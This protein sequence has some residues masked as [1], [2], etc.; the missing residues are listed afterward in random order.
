MADCFA[1]LPGKSIVTRTAA[2]SDKASMAYWFIYELRAL[3]W[4]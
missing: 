1:L 4:T 3:T 2:T